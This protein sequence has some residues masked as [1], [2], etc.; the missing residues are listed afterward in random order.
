[1]KAIL[2]GL[3]VVVLFGV[4]AVSAA[5]GGSEPPVPG[6]TAAITGVPSDACRNGAALC[7]TAFDALERC[8]RENPNSP[9]ACDKERAEADARCRDT[10]S[11][12]DTD[13]SKRPPSR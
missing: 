4:E 7:Q 11:A 2:T 10:N 1:M 13:G 3:L 5:L 6:D 8:E 9:D 12:C